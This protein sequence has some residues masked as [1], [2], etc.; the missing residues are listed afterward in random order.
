MIGQKLLSAVLLAGLLA[1]RVAAA[2][3]ANIMLPTDSIEKLLRAAPFHVLNMQGTRFPEDRTQRVTLQFGDSTLIAAKWAKAPYG[4]ETFNNN[5]RYELAA[6]RV[7][8]MFL[9]PLDYVV[10]PTVLRVVPL[11]WYRQRSPNASPTF[12]GT[13]SVLVVLQYW[14]WNVT[15]SGLWDPDRFASDSVYARHFADMN[16]LTYLIHH[17]D[18]NVG[19]LLISK[20][21]DNPRI[22]AVDNGLS[23]E[24]EASDRGTEWR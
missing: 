4:G 13:T 14:L 18:A 2:Q 24:S 5:P 8:K 21:P 23:F 1:P 7:Q 12:S 16:I 22:F 15:S 17:N 11:A 6:Y 10:P 19:N 9:D 3:D 20:M